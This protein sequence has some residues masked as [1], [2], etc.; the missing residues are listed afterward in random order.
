M[1]L[2]S[3]LVSIYNELD[4]NKFDIQKKGQA[5]ELVIIDEKG[6]V[7]HTCIGHPL[8]MSGMLLAALTDLYKASAY[9]D[10]SVEDY[11][12]SVKKK[13]IGFIKYYG[14]LVV[15]TAVN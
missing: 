7:Q 3:D 9:P 2:K 1:P 11:A 5:F 14:E 15:P 10:V 8:Q 12:E 4:E 6:L 13:L